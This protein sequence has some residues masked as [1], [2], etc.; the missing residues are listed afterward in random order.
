MWQCDD[1]LKRDD[2]V[3]LAIQ[4]FSVI[5]MIHSSLSH[6][7]CYYCLFGQGHFGQLVPLRTKSELKQ[8]NEKIYFCFLKLLKL[9]VFSKRGL[10]WTLGNDLYKATPPYKPQPPKFCDSVL[11][12][13]RHLATSPELNRVM[14]PHVEMLSL[15]SWIFYPALSKYL[16][17]VSSL[18][19]SWFH[20]S[21][22][23]LDLATLQRNTLEAA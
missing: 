3:F 6:H 10:L 9:K 13:I 20:R 19:Q 16:P 2:S 8:F 17:S 15:L 4:Q 1:V 18:L 23:S 5:S 22:C 12:C 14:K 11:Y 7:Q 21:I